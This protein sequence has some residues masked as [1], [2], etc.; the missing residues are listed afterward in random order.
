MIDR[1][2]L[3]RLTLILLLVAASRILRLDVWSMQPG[4]DEVWSVWQTLGSLQDVIRWTPYD[5]P[6]GYYV[7]L[8]FWR[9]LVGIHPIAVRMLSVF[10]MLIGAAAMYRAGRLWSG[11]R[12]GTFAAIAYS[13]L[14]YIIFLSIELR[15]YALLLGLMPLALW[16]MLRYFRRPGWQR[17]V[18]LGVVMAAMFYVSLTGIVAA[19]MLFLIALVRWP[20]AVWR[21]WLPAGVGVLLFLPELLNKLS[22]S[23]SRIHAL[24]AVEDAP[25]SAIPALY[26]QYAGDGAFVWLCLFVLAVVA[27][28]LRRRLWTR[29]GLALALWCAMPVAL[30]LTNN[31][32]GFFYSR[33]SWW[34]MPGLAL[35]IAWGLALL[36]R[37]VATT[38][39]LVMAGL[40]FLE[41][42]LDDYQIGPSGLALDFAFLAQNAQTGDVLLLD[43]E[44][45]CNVPVEL[46]YY[47]R[48]YFPQG[49]RYVSS[50]GDYRR[51]WYLSY[52]V[53]N[54]AL[55]SDVET[56]RVLMRTFGPARAQLKLYEAPPNPEGVAFENGLVFHGID[57]PDHDGPVVLHEGEALPVR[58]WWSAERPIDLDYS[59][60]L[61]LVSERA[62]T[63]AQH[64]G[65]PGVDAAGATSQWE[66]G[67]YYIDERV[68][69]LPHGLPQSTH[70]LRLS[71]Y[72]WADQ[73]R[74]PA[75]G[76]D[77]D[78]TLLLEKIHIMA[79]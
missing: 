37:L 41:P 60:G 56:N 28:A 64:D 24:S 43:P 39:G 2:Q 51:V 50:A 40:L 15:G 48:V 72:H 55:L 25:L 67:R 76:I 69:E 13:A 53:D 63:I 14:G 7:T 17:G 21:W 66:T 29:K 22:L 54:Q 18:L 11:R 9:N 62:G 5:W 6:P 79:W 31:L 34:V 23:V 33:Y 57:F 47:R 46:D 38:A 36:P 78:G 74:V 65:P 52:W 49:L 1:R 26:A 8:W 20:R 27:L 61:Y 16:L 30:Y 3:A 75:P 58:L 10:A 44:C 12:A 4:P 70:E 71:V 68:L 73:E 42:P 45:P 35:W 32:L 77:D 59:V 19:G